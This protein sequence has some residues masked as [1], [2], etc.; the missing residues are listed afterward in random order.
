MSRTNV[1]YL[2]YR[3]ARAWMDGLGIQ[4]IAE[5]E[6]Q[7]SEE[8]FMNKMI[9]DQFIVINGIQQNERPIIVIVVSEMNSFS[10]K[11]DTERVIAK[12]PDDGSVD[13]VIISLKI[14]T[15][16]S[17]FK[18]IKNIKHDW[19]L[20]DPRT[21]INSARYEI[22]RDEKRINDEVLYDTVLDTVKEL[23]ALPKEKL[24]SNPL[25]FW[26]G[27]KKGDILKVTSDAEDVNVFG[28]YNLVI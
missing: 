8:D 1:N 13:A 11:K 16:L 5:D 2:I 23:S 19:M 18:Y 22:I 6:K 15:Q 17:P 14:A 20:I 4:R 9:Y 3:N 12:I 21:H 27:A 10:K 7:L 28:Q 25:L 24:S 26:I